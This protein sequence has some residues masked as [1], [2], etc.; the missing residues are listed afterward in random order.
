MLSGRI[1]GNSIY[2]GRQCGALLLPNTFSSQQAFQAVLSQ[3]SVPA[4]VVYDESLVREFVRLLVIL[5]RPSRQVYRA[6]NA[7]SPI[8]RSGA[9]FSSEP[10]LVHPVASRNNGV[11]M[12][13]PPKDFLQ[14]FLLGNKTLTLGGDGTA[15]ETEVQALSK[16]VQDLYQKSSVFREMIDISSDTSFTLTVGRRDDN[17]SWGNTDGRVFMNINNISPSHSDTFQSLLAH[18]FAHASIDIGHDDTIK[19]IEMAVAMQV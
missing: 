4:P 15:S 19:Q 10:S 6:G 7:Q 3:S 1:E 18:E 16:V 8:A 5:F 11:D 2:S 14:S 12:I 9:T 17:T 13:P